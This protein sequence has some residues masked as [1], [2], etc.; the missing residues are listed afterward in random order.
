MI[1]LN[2]NLQDELL[3]TMQKI[4]EDAVIYHNDSESG[5]SFRECVVCGDWDEHH[6]NCPV[7]AI[8]LWIKVAQ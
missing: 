2:A 4:V 1:N 8:E 7:P 3:D 5:E 6:K